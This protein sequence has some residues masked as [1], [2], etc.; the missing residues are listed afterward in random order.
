M[1][2]KGENFGNMKG[3]RGILL[4]IDSEI[5]HLKRHDQ[6]ENDTWH[7]PRKVKSMRPVTNEVMTRGTISN[8]W[9]KNAHLKNSNKFYSALDGPWTKGQLM[10]NWRL[11]NSN[12]STSVVQVKK[13]VMDIPR[14][15][16]FH[17]DEGRPS[18]KRLVYPQYLEDPQ[19]L[20]NFQRDLPIKD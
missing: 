5:W 9:H 1:N 6:P 10:V 3:R 17:G 19:H 4:F 15:M 2:V 13:R 18:R 14:R 8:H 16:V 12:S 11:Y 20:G 7:I